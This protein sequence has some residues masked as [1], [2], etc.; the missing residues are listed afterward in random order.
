M[1]QHDAMTFHL[2]YSSKSPFQYTTFSFPLLKAKLYIL[3]LKTS[4]YL[5]D[6]SLSERHFEHI[7]LFQTR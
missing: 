2:A 7:T 4:C 5:F 3:P 6:R 1:M